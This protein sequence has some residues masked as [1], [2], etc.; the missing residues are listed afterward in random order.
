VN[1]NDKKSNETVSVAG[2]TEEKSEK[3]TQSDERGI[4][5]SDAPPSSSYGGNGHGRPARLV[6]FR[7]P[8]K[9]RD[10]E[11]DC[12]EKQTKRNRKR[13]RGGRLIPPTAPPGTLTGSQLVAVVEPEFFDCLPHPRA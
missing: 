12:R 1:E 13:N 2:G 6:D 3:P 7:P 5:L 8:R 9:E 10:C 4:E 11:R